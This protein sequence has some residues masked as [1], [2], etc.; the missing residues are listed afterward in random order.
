MTCEAFLRIAIVFISGEGPYNKRLVSRIRD[1]HVPIDDGAR[2]GGEPVVVAAEFSA[3]V[4]I[5]LCLSPLSCPTSK[6]VYSPFF[7]KTGM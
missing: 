7:A 3:T 6:Y 5:C 1:D 2:N 4:S